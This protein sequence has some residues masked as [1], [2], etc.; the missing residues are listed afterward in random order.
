MENI[1]LILKKYFKKKKE[2]PLI[3]LMIKNYNKSNFYFAIVY[4]VKIEAFKVLFLPLD[5]VNLKQLDE[6]VC[7]QFINYSTVNYLVDKL[8]DDRK[9]FEDENVRNKN[10]SG[11]SNY[12]IEINLNLDNENYVFKTTRYIPKDWIYLFDVVVTIFEHSPHIVSELCEDILILFRKESAFIP[13]QESFDF[14]LLRD[15]L[16]VLDKVIKGKNIGYDSINF[17][18]KIDDKYFSIIDNHLVIIEYNSCDIINTFCDS[19]N[20]NDYVYT[21]IMAIR[22]GVCKKFSKLTLTDRDKKKIQYYLCYGF[23]GENLKVIHGYCQ[24]LIPLD[25]Y[26]E[27]NIEFL[28]DKNGIE[29]EVNK[30]NDNI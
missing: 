4:N 27:G 15:E 12:K 29:K 7:Y 22:D 14:K 30:K 1:D 23:D 2:K 10:N 24:K 25:K 21:V 16:V 18:E 19:E 11:I 28:D 9:L 5:I 6:Y 17:L 26:K 8:N 3:Q 13:F 20:Y